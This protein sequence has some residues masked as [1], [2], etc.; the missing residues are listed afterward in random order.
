MNLIPD[1]SKDKPV[2]GF[3]LATFARAGFLGTGILTM[4]VGITHVAY[5]TQTSFPQCSGANC[6]G[7]ALVWGGSGNGFIADLN[8]GWRLVFSLA[9]SLFATYWTAFVLGLITTMSQFSGFAFNFCTRTWLHTS[10]WL[11][12]VAT[13]GCF[14]FAG[15]WGVIV[16]VFACISCILSF[17]TFLTARQSST[18]LQ[19]SLCH[20]KL[21]DCVADNA[22]VINLA[23]VLSLGVGLLTFVIGLIH[24]FNRSFQWCPANPWTECLGPSIRWNTVNSQNFVQSSNGP[25]A[26]RSIFTLDIEILG[27]LWGP[28]VLGYFTAIQHVQD[29]NHALLMSWPRVCLWFLF[30]ALFAN[31]GYAG[32]LGIICGFVS[33]VVA[34]LAVLITAGGGGTAPTHFA[35]RMGVPGRGAV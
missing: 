7:P 26:W 22:L 25:T 16:A 14:G 31:F 34:L 4:S 29:H 15:N 5:S 17:F 6:V 9:P 1:A 35:F 12:F 32:N 19:L 11:L 33:V 8:G 3:D 10:L 18:T 21:L 13:F 2:N 28:T 30:I 24:V 27:P 20:S 23:R